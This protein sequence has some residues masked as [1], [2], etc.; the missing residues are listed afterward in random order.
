MTTTRIFPL[1]LH[2]QCATHSKYN[3]THV[4]YLSKIKIIWMM[5]G[6]KLYIS[7]SGSKQF[8]CCFETLIYVISILYEFIVSQWSMIIEGLLES[9]NWG[10]F[11]FWFIRNIVQVFHLCRQLCY[12]TILFYPRELSTTLSFDFNLSNELLKL[13]HSV[14]ME[15]LKALLHC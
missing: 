14:K 11:F 15:I 10:F 6:L 3:G 7:I 9:Q 4:C 12:I 5:V 13:H 1:E 2:T 8:M